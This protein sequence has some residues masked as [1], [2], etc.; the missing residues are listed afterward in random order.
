[1]RKKLQDLI[2]VIKPQ[3]HSLFPS[4]ESIISRKEAIFPLTHSFP[5]HFEQWYFSVIQHT[6]A[7]VPLLLFPAFRCSHYKFFIDSLNGPRK[8]SSI[9][10]FFLFTFRDHNKAGHGTRGC[11]ERHRMLRHRNTESI[12]VGKR[13]RK[14]LRNIYCSKKNSCCGYIISGMFCNSINS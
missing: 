6:E 13:H 10:S 9:T 4:T 14:R 7:D 8:F 2:I 11:K 5:I 1:M 3:F 12:V